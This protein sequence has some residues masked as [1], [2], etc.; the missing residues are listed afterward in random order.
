MTAPAWR[1]SGR[2]GDSIACVEVADG[3]LV[4]DSN[5]PAVV[6]AFTPAAWTAFLAK[7]RRT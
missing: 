6:L 3:V 7:V 5:D 1:K 2:C 4:R